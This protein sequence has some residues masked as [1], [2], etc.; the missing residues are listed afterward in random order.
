MLLEKV[1]LYIST[2][3]NLIKKP[4]G[5]CVPCSASVIGTIGY[6]LLVKY[7]YNFIDNIFICIC[8]VN[9]N[10]LIWFLTEKLVITVNKL[11]N[12]K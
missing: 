7:E 11:R 6:V 9:L 4:L 12:G 2:L 5:D 3:P 8:C 10:I 1:G